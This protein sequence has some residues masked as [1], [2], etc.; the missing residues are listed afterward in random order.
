MANAEVNSDEDATG[1]DPADDVGV[2]AGS[3]RHH[4]LHG[5]VRP[6]VGLR[7][8]RGGDCRQQTNQKEYLAN[9]HAHALWSTP[10]FRH[11]MIA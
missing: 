8:D 5:P 3:E 9:P 6:R 7:P 11:T 10:T 2:A 4:N 1:D